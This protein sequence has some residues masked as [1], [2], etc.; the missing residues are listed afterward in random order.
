MKPFVYMHDADPLQNV[1]GH[2]PVVI[3]AEKPEVIGP[4]D[5]VEMDGCPVH[6]LVEVI[7]PAIKGVDIAFLTYGVGIPTCWPVSLLRLVTRAA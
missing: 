4:G 2:E 3:V 6:F 5:I 7:V 1:N